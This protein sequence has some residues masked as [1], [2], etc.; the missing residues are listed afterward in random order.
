MFGLDV[1]G[2]VDGKVLECVVV[3]DNGH[4]D[5]VAQR[6]LAAVELPPCL[7]DARQRIV[8]GQIDGRRTDIHTLCIARGVR[9]GTVK[10]QVRALDRLDVVADVRGVELDR[11]GAFGGHAEGPGVVGGRGG[12]VRGVARPRDGTVRVGGVQRDAER[13]LLPLGRH[14]RCGR[15]RSVIRVAACERQLLDP[16]VAGV[17]YIE[18]A[19]AGD[20]YV[21]GKLELACG[22]TGGADRLQPRAI[23]CEADDAGQAGIGDVQGA[24]GVDVDTL[25]E[26]EVVGDSTGLDPGVDGIEK[27]GGTDPGHVVLE[28]EAVLEVSDPQNAARSHR[29]AV[30]GAAKRQFPLSQEAP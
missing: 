4:R 12:P 30:G 18:I 24:P 1:A 7:L 8:R 6:P 21:L 17:C 15:R 28:Y 20:P 29:H 26:L 22:G 11:V 25:R 9:R 10:T 16:V 13:R 14:V 27:R 5:R 23:A 2:V 3:V 19:V